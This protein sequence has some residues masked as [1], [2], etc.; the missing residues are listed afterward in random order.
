MPDTID[1]DLKEIIENW[2]KTHSYNP[3]KSEVYAL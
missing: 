3:R 1:D 2:A